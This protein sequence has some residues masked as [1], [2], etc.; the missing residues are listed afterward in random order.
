[1]PQAGFQGVGGMPRAG[2]QGSGGAPQ[3]GFQGFGGFGIAGKAGIGGSPSS[4]G[5]GGSPDSGSLKTCNRLCDALFE[6]CAEATPQNCR[7]NCVGELVASSPECRAARQDAFNCIS[8][9][10]SGKG[11]NCQSLPLLVIPCAP[12]LARAQAACTTVTPPPDPDCQTFEKSAPG[13]CGVSERCGNTS[14]LTLCRQTSPNIAE[15]TCQIN[16]V[17]VA[18]NSFKS[19]ESTDLCQFVDRIACGPL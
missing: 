2:F 17:T 14:Y 13:V 8:R 3:A 4:G 15:C 12:V 5:G 1:V 19:Q 11:G 6:T 7:L 18:S 9:A 10:I 16:G